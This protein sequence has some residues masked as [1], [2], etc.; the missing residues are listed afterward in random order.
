[1]DTSYMQKEKKEFVVFG[2]G[3]FGENIATVLAEGGCEVLAVDKDAD[4]VQAIADVVTYAVCAD[5]TDPEALHNLG[6][7]NFDGA[8]IGIGRNFEASVMLSILLKEM[9]IPFILARAQSELHGKV[10]R[11]V[12]VDKVIFPEKETGVRI[13]NN[14]L[15]GNLFD[16][17]EL[18]STISI[19]DVH[20]HK[21]WTGKT[22]RDLNMRSA[23][24]I[25]V[26]ALKRNGE[27]KVSPEPDLS[28][29]DDDVLVV[30]GKNS[31]LSALAKADDE[32]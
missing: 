22:M 12:G 8:I 25:N 29:R 14:L 24:H 18:S 3:I 11:K 13:A 4:R 6:I 1:M 20:V 28:F 5:A 7:S 16:A 21:D 15:M 2:L 9:G 30:I 10:L 31:E 19:M 23:Y 26:I 17:I 32:K 27:V